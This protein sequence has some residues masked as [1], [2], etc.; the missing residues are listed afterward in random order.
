M[1]DIY[2]WSVLIVAVFFTVFG[3]FSY[4]RNRKE[5][6]NKLFALLSLAF[7]MWSYTW[8][9]LLLT[10][11]NEQ[12]AFLWARLLNIGAIFIT[13]FYFHW[14]LSILDLHK[15]KKILVISGYL[16]TLLFFV[17]SFSDKYVTGVHSILSFPFWPT[18]GPLYKW[19]LI[20]GYLCMVGYSLYLLFKAFNK[21]EGEKKYQIGYVII[22]SLMGFGGGAMNF[23]LMYNIDIIP[24]F[25][26]FAII[27][28][29]LILSYAVIKYHLMNTKV[30]TVEILSALISAVLLVDALLSSGTEFYLKFGLFIGVVIFSIIL[31][32]SVLKETRSRE[33]II[34]LAKSLKK[35]NIELQKLDKAKSEFISIASHQLRTPVSVIKG[36]TSMMIE[37]DLEKFPI[38][39]KNRFIEGLWNKSC[40]LENIIND[41]L[42]ATEMTNFKYRV[43]KE[44]AE[45]IDL[46]EL[47]KKTISDFQ[48]IIKKKGVD[49]ILKKSIKSLPRI[50][51]Q[52]QYLQEAFSNLIDNAIK[53]T[54][55]KGKIVISI[56]KKENNVIISIEDN[57]I[58]IPKEEIPGL[59][60]KF[61]RGSNAREMYTDGSGLGLFIVRE[62]IE[63]HY[64]KVWMES[65]LNKGTTF[66]I[67]LPIHS[68]KK[69]NVKNHIIND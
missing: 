31:I 25:G 19:F 65:E 9:A 38:E 59:F 49:V 2:T 16:V 37:G 44:K 51:G 35:A 6:M 18:A 46:E 52:K 61:I 32:H 64:G 33:K 66:F 43:K 15:K 57:G 5:L 8:F 62:V 22:G 12:I 68:S 56:T 10:R 17:L 55:S 40:K 54:S 36:I 3:S 30:A 23:P 42:N 67:S 69:I 29:P 63:G 53:Y 58:G 14:V 45:L 26:V 50:N 13:I 48:S 28:C 1:L 47:I 24:P 41:I 39:K 60:I 7:A 27:A 11:E 4:L 21:S 34:K 20:F